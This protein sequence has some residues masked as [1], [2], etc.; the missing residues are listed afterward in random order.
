MKKLAKRKV[1]KRT[2]VKRRNPDYSNL[3]W[4][5]D[6]YIRTQKLVPSDAKYPA[7]E[8][9]LLEEMKEQIREFRLDIDDGGYHKN[10]LL[11]ELKFK[12]YHYKNLIKIIETTK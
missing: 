4:K 7:T 11:E 5:L 2:S 10:Q 12:V 3:Q 1:I 6:D 8:R 9:V